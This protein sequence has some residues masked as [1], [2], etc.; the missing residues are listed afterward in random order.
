MLNVSVLKTNLLKIFDA[1]H[2]NFVG[3]PTT[4]VQGVDN[5]ANAYNQYALAATDAS[6][7]AVAVTNI[8][9][10]KTSLLGLTPGSTFADAAQ[11][12]DDA[13]VAYWTA[14]AFTFGI[15][16]LPAAPGVTVG[17]T[18]PWTVEASSVVSLV[19]PNV[20]KGLLLPEFTILS[21][22]A[23]AKATAI[24]NAFHT[25][26]TTAVT[27]L[28]SGFDSTPFPAGPLPMTNTCTI[29]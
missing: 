16:P 19:T 22:D 11:A 3:W 15:P 21:G 26:T 25:A 5:I 10:F 18:P 28:I 13:F 4:L 14:G 12:F 24:A 29:F 1:T 20:L 17:L 7:E 9:L 2:L 23:D 27:V 8:A 6:T